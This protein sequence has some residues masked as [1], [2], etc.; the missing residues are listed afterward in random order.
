MN[1][2]FLSTMLEKLITNYSSLDKKM[3]NLTQLFVSAAILSLLG[4]SVFL[5]AKTFNI[6]REPKIVTK[7]KIE[8]RDTCNGKNTN[9]PIVNNVETN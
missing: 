4:V 8:Y 3:K 9:L 2:G 1:V 5:G 6:L 7:T